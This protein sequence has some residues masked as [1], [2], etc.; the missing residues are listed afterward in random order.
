MTYLDPARRLTAVP[1][2]SLGQVTTAGLARH[3]DLLPALHNKG[4]RCKQAGQT[5]S[6]NFPE[7]LK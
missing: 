4:Q 1:A 3:L 2:R 5:Q 7:I 6:E